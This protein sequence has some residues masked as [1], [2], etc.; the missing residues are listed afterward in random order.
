MNAQSFN[1]SQYF[2]GSISF[3]VFYNPWYI[4]AEIAKYLPRASPRPYKG[5]VLDRSVI[6]FVL[7]QYIVTKATARFQIFWRL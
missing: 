6:D 1:V 5:E 4:P 3:S 7:L 2:L